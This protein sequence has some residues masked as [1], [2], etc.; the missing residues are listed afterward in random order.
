MS[1]TKEESP[2]FILLRNAF[3][4]CKRIIQW[5]WMQN[6]GPVIQFGEEFYSVMCDRSGDMATCFNSCPG[7]IITQNKSVLYNNYNVECM[8]VYIMFLV[9]ITPVE[10]KFFWIT[11]SR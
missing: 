3:V 4:C 11:H 6:F 7:E 1:G 2:V 9:T 8:Y 10:T 5:T